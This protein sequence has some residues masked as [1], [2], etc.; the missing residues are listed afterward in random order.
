[1]SVLQF[2][3]GKTLPWAPRFSLTDRTVLV[4][5]YTSAAEYDH[6]FS[7]TTGSGDTLYD[8]TESIRFDPA[9]RLLASVRM[10][11]PE[12]PEPP[13]SALLTLLEKEPVSELP[14]LPPGEAFSIEVPRA[15]F[16]DS[17]GRY[18]A[19]M[20]TEPTLGQR[21]VQIA[22][23][24]EIIVNVGEL[25][26]WLLNC[27]SR[28]LSYGWGVGHS[29]ADG[30]QDLAP[31]LAR[32]LKLIDDAFVLRLED[33]EPMALQ[34]LHQLLESTNRTRDC[35]QRHAFTQAIE[36]IIDTFS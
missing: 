17:R 19:A 32:F 2:E 12:R 22:Q 18:I 3:R 1:M 24:F 14:I 13:P 8:K 27:P 15:L 10:H 11:V 25:E 20:R 9:T 6:H 16:V 29:D 35:P 28:Y 21:R 7:I 33:N 30:W 23:D 36:S 4:A 5:A 26:G 31:L 34:A